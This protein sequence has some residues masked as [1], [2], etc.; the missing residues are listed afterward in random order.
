MRVMQC[1][2]CR[3]PLFFEN[4]ICLTCST[5]VGFRPDPFDL[6]AVDGGSGPFTWCAN[7][8]V[9]GCSWAVEAP[10]ELCLS[11]SLTRT[12]PPDGTDVGEL[13]VATEGAKRRLV[14]HLVDLG[15][16]L[17]SFRDDPDG[18]LGFDLLSGR[19]DSSVVIGHEDGLITLDVDEADPAHRERVRRELGEAYRTVLGHLRHEVGHYY[20]TV[21]VDQGGAVDAFRSRFGDERA[22]YADAVGAHYGG[23]G[24]DG[25]EDG[26]VSAYATM[27]PWED[28]AET[29]AHYLH[30]RDTVQTAAE[31]GVT[32]RA[33][34]R[35][36]AAAPSPTAD[37]GP[38]RAL[39]RDWIDLAGALNLVNRSMGAPDLYPFVLAPKVIDKLAFVDTLV[40]AAAGSGSAPVVRPR[41]TGSG[42]G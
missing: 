22:D 30:I 32:V 40:R 24:P 20:W 29:F 31:A 28:W 42:L 8:P 34:W 39:V 12:R 6:V 27:H 38:F 11:C 19:L 14:A 25:W 33:S 3:A 13:F 35:G 9:A 1:P 15:L 10:G 7:R 2:T 23:P 21:L 4:D 17:V 26:F 5:T 41:L 37:E 16:P 36:G 18:G